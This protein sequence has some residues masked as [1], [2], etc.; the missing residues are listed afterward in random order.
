MVFYFFTLGVTSKRS[1]FVAEFQAKN[2]K[3][4]QTRIH[5]PHEQGRFIKAPYKGLKQGSNG[6]VG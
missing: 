5:A 3:K 4:G 6:W 1:H 2:D